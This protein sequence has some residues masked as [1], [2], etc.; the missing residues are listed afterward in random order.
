MQQWFR[1]RSAR[2]L[3][4]LNGSI[5]R[6]ADPER[7]DLPPLPTWANWSNA[8]IV[9]T[10]SVGLAWSIFARID[11]TISVQGKLDAIA[12]SQSIQSRS[13]GVITAIYVQEGQRVQRGQ[14]LI[15]LDK[16]ALLQKLAL[17]SQQRFN[18]TKQV[19]VLRAARQGIPL[20]K[21]AEGGI[22]VPQEILNQAQTRTLLVAQLSDNANGLN[23]EQV[24]R[25]NLAKQELENK[26]KSA[27]LDTAMLQTQANQSQSQIDE[28]TTRFAAEREVLAR[29][30]PLAEQG[31]I[32]RLDLLKRA[33]EA[34][35]V[36]SQMNQA[37]LAKSKLDLNVA[38][39]QI[40]RD[41][42]ITAHRRELQEQ[43]SQLD[44]QFDQT[45]VTTQRQILDL[46]GQI[47][48]VRID[49]SQQDLR[50]PVDGIVFN[51]SSR[52]PGA[53]TQ[54]GQS[55]LQ[56]TPLGTLTAR[57]QIP[58]KE[59]AALR[60]GLSADVRVDAFPFTEFG[61]IKGTIGNIGSDALPADNAHPGQTL[62]PAEIRL[63]QQFLT[64]A[65]KEF[66]LTPGMSVNVNI[67]TGSRAPIQWVVGEVIKAV[68]KTQSV[69]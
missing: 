23:P 29:L 66:A 68:D 65:G 30:Q 67:K 44:N 45:I 18:L 2:V 12:S 43:L 32:A 41:N 40:G 38:Q 24:Q 14:L 36:Q 19:A 62:F 22:V 50:S 53:V 47:E 61:L 10:L 59:V 54:S 60:A 39:S 46:N 8:V 1:D 26:L 3:D 16:T 57:V 48:Q 63:S 51:L 20:T 7:L 42:V 37:Q 25:L 4:R 21:F 27:E 55:L 31:A 15:Q 49:L 9:A 28:A 34:L 13:S 64:K 11:T 52:L 6:A 69:P 56:V 33:E 58:N 17:L 5:D 35:E